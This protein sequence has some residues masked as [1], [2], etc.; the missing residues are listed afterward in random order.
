MRKNQS[1]NILLIIGL[2]VVA[3]TPF[4]VTL[5]TPPLANALCV[6]QN[7]KSIVVCMPNPVPAL[8]ITLGIPLVLGTALIVVS[9]LR[10]K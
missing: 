7:L 4:S 1:N 6:P 9:V 5:L 8:L 10:R 2:I 3:V